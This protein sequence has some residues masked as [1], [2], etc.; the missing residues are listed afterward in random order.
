LS[1]DDSVELHVRD[2]GAGFP[3]EFRDRAFERFSRAETSHN[4]D[5]SGLGLAIVEAIA[6]AHRG[7]AKVRNRNGGGVDAWMVLPLA[8]KQIAAPTAGHARGS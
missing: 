7:E 5:G 6:R 2:R 4:Q 8:S 1:H 3:E